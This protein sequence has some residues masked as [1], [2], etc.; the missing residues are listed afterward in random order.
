MHWHLIC[1]T[2]ALFHSISKIFNFEFWPGN[3]ENFP[4]CDGPGSIPGGV[5]N[6]N[7][8]P[9]IGCVSFVFC[10]VLSPAEALTL[11]WPHIHGGP[12]L[13]ICLVFRSIDNC[14]PCRHLTHG[15]LGCK[16]RGGVSPRLLEGKYKKKK[17]RKKLLMQNTDTHIH[18]SSSSSSPYQSVLSKGSAFTAN[19]ETKVAVL[20]KGRSSTPILGTKVAV[21]TE[22]NTCCSFPLLS[23]AHAHPLLHLKR[24]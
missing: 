7:F 11:C 9:E 5:R 23:A 19:A 14:S 20:S 4:L 18:I 3:S 21:L 8:S 17:E 22:I 13:C 6:F 12:P 16:S 2:N 15:H 1:Y 24:P 10:P